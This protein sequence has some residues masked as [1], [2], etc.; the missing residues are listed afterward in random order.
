MTG[1]PI[2]LNGARV[3]ALVVGGGRV[4]T[5]KALALAEAYGRVVVV[6]PTLSPEL[7]AAADRMPGR[8]ELVQRAFRDTDVHGRHLVI[9]ATDGRE[10]NARVAAAAAAR[11]VLCNVADDPDGSGF[12][13]AAVHRAGPLVIGVSAGGVP[14][15]AARVRDAIAGGVDARLGEA[16][17]RLGELRSRLLAAGDAQ[18]W[19]AAS[20]ELVGADFVAA[21]ERGTFAER[22]QRWG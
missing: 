22:V 16:V 5:R 4:A 8:L 10:V 7:R 15:A 14:A 18:R 11:G 12:W 6:A 17:E 20:A 13:T 1:L 2:V 3:T 9:A 21:V 19:R